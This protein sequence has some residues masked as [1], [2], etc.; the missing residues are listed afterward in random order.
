MA[1]LK[2][3][4]AQGW[5]AD[6]G[7]RAG[8]LVKL[9]ELMRKEFPGTDIKGMPHI[10]SKIAAWKKSYNSLSLMLDVSGVGF[11]AKGT[12]MIDCDTDQWQQIVKKDRNALNMRFKS[13]PLFD[14]WGDVFGKDRA[15]GKN[16]EDVME[17]MHKM[18]QADNLAQGGVYGTMPHVDEEDAATEDAEDSVCQLEKKEPTAKNSRK[19]RKANDDMRG[20]YE[21]LHEFGKEANAR[22]DNLATRVGYE[23]ADRLRTTW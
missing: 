19:R 23:L 2:E 14:S 7:F 4:V 22:L 9:E 6:N 13:W 10:N 12:F 15:N 16:A 11:N 3:L 20:V 17:A 18:Y 21:F 5:K 8:Y 1:S